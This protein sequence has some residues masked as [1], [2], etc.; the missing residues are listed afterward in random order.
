MT[1]TESESDIRFIVGQ[2]LL[3]IGYNSL[4]KKKKKIGPG[5]GQ[6][7]VNKV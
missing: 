7:T 5:S 1:P 6:T 4:L 3:N 2:L